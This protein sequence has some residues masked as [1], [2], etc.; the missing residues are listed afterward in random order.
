MEAVVSDHETALEYIV[1]PDELLQ[2]KKLLV[3]DAVAAIKDQAEV[4]QQRIE[5][6]VR[7]A[8]TKVDG[9]EARIAKLESERLVLLKGA[10]A[11]A[12]VVGIILS[13]LFAWIKSKIHFG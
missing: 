5:E 8:I 3:D 13:S 9:F 10:V 4:H 11:Y 2:L 1:T 7:P 12:T 6:I